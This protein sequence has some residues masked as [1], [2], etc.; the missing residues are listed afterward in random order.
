MHNIHRKTPAFESLF[1]DAAGLKAC[2]LIKRRLEHRRFPVNI[3]KFLRT[4]FFIEDLRWL[5][6]RCDNICDISII[7]KIVANS[8]TMYICKFLQVPI[9]TQSQY[10]NAKQF[11]I[12]LWYKESRHLSSCL[13]EFCLID[14]ILPVELILVQRFVWWCLIKLLKRKC[15]VFCSYN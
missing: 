3:V 13:E 15:L 4:V 5:L 1:N 11:P 7:W 6:L 14:N 12:T 10:Q 8:K 2:N 9:L